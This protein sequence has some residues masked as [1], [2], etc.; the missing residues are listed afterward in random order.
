MR[1][2]HLVGR[3]ELGVG[4]LVQVLQLPQSTVSRHLKVLKD[5]G[6]IR[7]RADG[8][9]AWFR[10]VGADDEE[11]PGASRVALWDVVRSAHEP[12]EQ[13]REDGERLA[14]VLD[15]RRVDSRTFFGRVHGQ[16]DALRT[17]LY[18][19]SFVVPALLGL[20]P[21][22]LVV[23]ELGCG[24][25]QNLVHLA[26]VASTV[27]GVD[28]EARM[29]EAA[30]VRTG[31]LPNVELR[32]GGLE[33]LPLA[34]AEVDAALCVLVLHHVPDLRTAFA[35][36]ARA[37]RPGGTVAVTDMRAHQRTAYRDTMGHA[38]LGFTEA[39]VRAALPPSLVVR[40]WADLPADPGAHGPALFTAV[41]TRR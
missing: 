41:L 3:E 29:L 22:G 40:R 32:Q 16:W 35:E 19:T 18:G 10:L 21:D 5:A 13:A 39:D 26:S 27:I 6:W 7:R 28:R 11:P 30:R 34:D 25:G 8:S 14:A 20:L 24:T 2:L 31:D 36:I 12:S 9:A 17:E 38:H 15:A 23:A 37:V 33:D 4:E 1:L